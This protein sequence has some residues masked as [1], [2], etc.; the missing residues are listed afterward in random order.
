MSKRGGDAAFKPGMIVSNEPGYYKN[1]S[2][3]IRIESL[4]AVVEKK[5]KKDGADYLGFETITCAPIDT[6]L[7]DAS[8][9]HHNPE[10]D[11]LNRYHAWVCEK[12]APG[13]NQAQLAWLKERCAP[14]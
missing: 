9:P 13:L 14:I 11:W 1:D 6:R 4:V 10:K 12:L 2:F 5:S 3:G 7:I 8:M